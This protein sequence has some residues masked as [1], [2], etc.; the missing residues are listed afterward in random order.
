MP[1]QTFGYVV[2]RLREM[3]LAGAG[4]PELAAYLRERCGSD[5]FGACDYLG[6]AF[7][8]QNLFTFIFPPGPI[9]AELEAR[10][11]VAVMQKR[12][13]WEAERFPDLRC[14]RDY[15]AFLRF[16]RDEGV[17]VT[18][19]DWTPAAPV[20]RLHGVYD[21]DSAEP[22]WSARRG[23]RL[24]ATLNRLL[25]EDLVVEGP[26]DQWELRN[27]RSA[28]GAAWGPQLP[29]IQFVPE[30]N[31]SNI[32]SVEALAHSRFYRGRWAQLYP[33]Q[34]VEA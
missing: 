31:V 20:Y 17:A 23:E 28:A 9:D 29:V 12:A 2:R 19:C 7:K 30:G 14:P 21:A 3:A 22:V 27:D 10:V 15:L 4:A 16:A 33:C 32:L 11:N 13:L 8:Q 26:H 18:V 25:G 5:W 24:R 34:P 1:A 6:V